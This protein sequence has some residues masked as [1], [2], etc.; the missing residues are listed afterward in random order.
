[1][2]GAEE[3]KSW[4]AFLAEEQNN[5]PKVSSPTNGLLA[6]GSRRQ[7]L[8]EDIRTRRSSS[9]GDIRPEPRVYDINHG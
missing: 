2:F 7:G 5:K 9:V 3:S 8:A 1:M 4:R 6:P